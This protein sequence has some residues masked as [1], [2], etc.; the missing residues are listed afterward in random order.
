MTLDSTQPLTEMSAKNISWGRCRIQHLPA[1]EDGTECSETSAYKNSGA[2]ELPGRKH[3]TYRIR[4]KFEIK[5]SKDLSYMYCTSHQVYVSKNSC[6][7]DIINM[8]S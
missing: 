2:G 1:Y 8:R 3:T 6:L 7:L 4:R 5:N